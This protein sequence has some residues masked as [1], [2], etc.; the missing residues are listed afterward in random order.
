MLFRFWMMSAILAVNCTSHEKVRIIEGCHW[1]SVIM[2]DVEIA[3]SAISYA[4]ASMLGRKNY[5]YYLP[6]CGTPPRRE[7]TTNKRKLDLLMASQPTKQRER[8]I[9]RFYN[10]GLEEHIKKTIQFAVGPAGKTT[11]VLTKIQSDIRMWEQHYKNVIKE[12]DSN[13]NG[14]EDTDR[15]ITML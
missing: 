5:G 12:F 10:D 2:E 14:F 7:S 4:R 6:P 3:N 13:Y 8:V 1:M 11:E 9:A 15:M